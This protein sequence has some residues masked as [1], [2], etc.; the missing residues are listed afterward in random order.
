MLSNSLFQKTYYLSLGLFFG[1]P[2]DPQTQIVCGIFF[3]I[4]EIPQGYA[5]E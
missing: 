1:A 4:A 3:Q 2:F 5:L